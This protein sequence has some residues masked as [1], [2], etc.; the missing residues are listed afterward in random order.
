MQSN[1]P[2][3]WYTDP[4]DPT[5]ELWWDGAKWHPDAK[6]PLDA[7]ANE[8]NEKYCSNCS[9]LLD[10]W[11]LN[12]LK[13]DQGQNGQIMNT[14]NKDKAQSNPIKES[15][16]K[17]ST[18]ITE[19]K[20]F[21]ELEGFWNSFL[22]YILSILL[23]GLGSL[24]G[25]TEGALLAL[26]FFSIMVFVFANGPLVSNARKKGIPVISYWWHLVAIGIGITL[27]YFLLPASFWESDTYTLDDYLNNLLIFTPMYISIALQMLQVRLGNMGGATVGSPRI[28]IK[29]N[30]RFILLFI[31]LFNI[32]DT[33]PYII[34]NLV[35]VDS[36]NLFRKITSSF[37]MYIGSL[38]WVGGLISG[39]P[40]KLF[41]SGQW[42]RMLVITIVTFLILWAV[43]LG[44]WQLSRT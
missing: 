3:G 17:K 14:S 11:W 18:E 23:A 35:Y 44:A 4:Y 8:Q 39:W 24:K 10:S 37:V 40:G 27:G 15:N 2:K 26:S 41:S 6:R 13:C 33:L 30:V 12:C 19:Y 9:A 16:P 21:T 28:S 42:K 25:W 1:M 43:G 38:A 32:S 7:K 29:N 20:N 5:Q 36:P 34:N 22:L 31:T